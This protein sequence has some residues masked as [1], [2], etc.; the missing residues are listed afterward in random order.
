MQSVNN[1]WLGFIDRSYQQIKN[2]CLNSL[3]T[4]AP[5]L[6]DFSESQPL[7]LIL[8][9][10]S[11][12]AEMINYYLDNAARESFIGTARL[13]SSVIKS[14]RVIDY[15]IK[16]RSPESVNVIFQALNADNTPY[17]FGTNQVI[18]MGTQVSSIK[19]YIFTSSHNNT[20]LSGNSSITISCE[21][22]TPQTAIIIGITNANKNQAFSLGLKYVEGSISLTINSVTWN[23][24]NTFARSYL[25]DLHFIVDIDVDGL[26]KVIF[27]DGIKGLIPP[28]GFNV[29]VNY[30]TTE[31]GDKSA[32][33]LEITTLISDLSSIIGPDHWKVSNPDSSSGGSYYEDLESIKRNAPLFVRTLDRA[34]SFT[35]FTDMSQLVAGVRFGLAKPCCQSVVIIY[36]AP[37][38]S[39]NEGG[40]AS[41]GLLTSVEGYFDT[42]RILMGRTVDAIPAGITH[43]KLGISGRANFRIPVSQANDAI[44]NALQTNFG[45]N[46]SGINRPIRLSDLYGVI[47][48]LPEIDWADIDYI[49]TEPYARPINTPNPLVWDRIIS[50]DNSVDKIKWA[51]EK[52]SITDQFNLFKSAGFIGS[53]L[54]GTT[55]NTALFSELDNIISFV[56]NAGAYSTG[57]RWEFTTY[58]SNGNIEISD[59]TVPVIVIDAPFNDVESNIS[60]ASIDIDTS[61]CNN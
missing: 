28:S 48:T 50:A 12:M 11:G 59:F 20:L 45:Y 22:S 27:G 25:G 2:S 21:E 33:P 35:D 46:S 58:P 56:I 42:S 43:I 57:D 17:I 14:T 29:I 39:S 44:K 49:K 47:K 36:I 38:D 53:F 24:V 19:G 61:N 23:L 10:F 31:G 34:V 18:P 51:I 30:K 7:V 26:A 52:S 55:V 41:D 60:I 1:P 15:R 6:T 13:T 9:M 8:S 3:K 54:I 5:E 4:I 37:K 40:I 16:S 32:L